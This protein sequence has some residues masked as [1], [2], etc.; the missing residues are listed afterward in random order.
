MS[1]QQKI[2]EAATRYQV[3]EQQ[4]YHNCRSIFYILNNGSRRT[5]QKDLQV[6]TSCNHTRLTAHHEAMLYPE[7][8]GYTGSCWRWQEVRISF[9]I[10]TYLASFRKCFNPSRRKEK[11]DSQSKQTHAPHQVKT[12]TEK[13]AEAVKDDKRSLQMR[14][15]K[16]STVGIS[17][18]TRKQKA[19]RHI[20]IRCYST[21]EKLQK[22]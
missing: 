22:L 5:V 13:P 19:H 16:M 2:A 21:S 6:N 3:Q 1:K 20:K 14:S 11:D 10:E 8:L 18:E 7:K 15:T 12:K 17:S 4:G 9:S